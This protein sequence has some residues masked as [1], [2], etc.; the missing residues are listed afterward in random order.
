MGGAR[1]R[2]LY[3]GA[4]ILGAVAINALADQAGFHHPGATPKQITTVH[5]HRHCS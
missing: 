1:T 3:L 5:E 2:H 4:A